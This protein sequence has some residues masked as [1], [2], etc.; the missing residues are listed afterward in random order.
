MRNLVFFFLFFVNYSFAQITFQKTY[1][2]A[3]EDYFNSV[4][5]IVDGGYIMVG[6]T[7][8]LGAGADDVYLVKTDLNGDTLWTRTYG[9]TGSDIAYCVQQTTDSGYIVIGHTDGTGPGTNGVYLIKTN[10]TGDSL[11][12]KTYLTGSN[13]GS[14]GWS[15]KQ[16][17]DGG[18]I[19]DCTGSWDDVAYFIKTNAV[20]DTLWTKSYGTKSGSLSELQQTADSGYIFTASGTSTSLYMVKTDVNGNLVWKKEYRGFSINDVHL[21]YSVKQTP[22]GGYIA[23]GSAWNTS[24]D[25]YLVK[26]NAFG[27]T[28]W[29]KSFGGDSV[30][31]GMSIFLTADS[32]Y[33]I[34]GSSNSF[35]GGN[36]DVYLIKTNATGD[37]LWT[38]SFGNINNEESKSVQQTLD[39]GYILAGSSNSFGAGGY[40]AYLIKTD[41]N[42]NSG[43]YE[44]S[45]AT[46]ISSPITIVSIP[47]DTF[48][49]D[50][51][52]VNSYSAVLGC[53]GMISTFCANVG[54]NEIIEEN[55]VNIYPNPAQDIFMINTNNEFINVKMEICNVLGE[56]I[57]SEKLNSKHE[58]IKCNEFPSG[59]YFIILK[60]KKKIMS[61]KIIINK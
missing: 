57:Y 36:D 22:D 10:I 18:Y 24:W 3:Q 50:P 28:L 7:T 43:C 9:E 35:G 39:G 44:N 32:G 40:D 53:G 37:S 17:F 33:I 2:G 1:G 38:K 55:E 56:I 52:L 13:E 49:L 25:V 4:Q 31:V 26:T 41:V 61:K 46:I 29:T 60:T 12:T 8:S 6:A 14:V 51:I 34:A 27:D 15:V 42:G 16:T 21:A 47:V 45:T 11:W 5:Q 48:L 30:D 59:I 23:V 58:S 20:G 54:I 19:L